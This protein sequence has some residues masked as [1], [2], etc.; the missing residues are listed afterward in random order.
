M[1][2]INLKTYY[3]PLYLIKA[4]KSKILLRGGLRSCGATPDFFMCVKLLGTIKSIL[5]NNF[6]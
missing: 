6:K 3:F 2:M 1:A 5:S 4:N